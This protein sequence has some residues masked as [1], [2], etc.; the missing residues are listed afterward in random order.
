MEARRIRDEQG[1]AGH[2]QAQE[3]EHAAIRVSGLASQI[4]AIRRNGR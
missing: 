2:V 1:H 3:L 4:N